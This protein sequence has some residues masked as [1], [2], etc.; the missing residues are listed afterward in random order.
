MFK[1]H[2][3]LSELP[4]VTSGDHS[5]HRTEHTLTSREREVIRLFSEGLS[6]KQVG[7]CLNLAEGTVKVHLLRVYKKGGVP[8]R[9]ALTAF[10]LIDWPGVV[11]DKVLP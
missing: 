11:D 10:A 7:R 2:R 5:M 6:N 1:V 8:N 4:A 9:T 3:E